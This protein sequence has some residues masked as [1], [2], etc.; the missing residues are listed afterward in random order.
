MSAWNGA[1]LSE[2]RIASTACI[3][4]PVEALWR[5]VSDPA[6]HVRIDGS[7]MLQ[8][9]AD[10]RPLV[11]VGETF[12]MDMDREPLGDIPEMGK[13]QVTNTVTQLVPNRLI[14]WVVALTGTSPAGLHYGWELD[15]VSATETEVTNY[16]DWSKV[17][18]GIR[19]RYRWPIVPLH[20][21]DKSVA[22]LKRVAMG[23]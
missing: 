4:A 5:I 12:E 22:N 21:L 13:Y 23:G 18:E 16:C 15:A 7:G 14:E 8:A 6:G 17:S 11:A 9:A 10:A 2:N 20:M 19:N 1:T 3:A